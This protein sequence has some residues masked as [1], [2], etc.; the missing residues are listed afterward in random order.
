MELTAGIQPDLTSAILS[1]NPHDVPKNY[2]GLVSAVSRHTV[3]DN[4]LG[5]VGGASQLELVQFCLLGD[6]MG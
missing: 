6:K 1:H 2:P 5:M 3:R 4:T